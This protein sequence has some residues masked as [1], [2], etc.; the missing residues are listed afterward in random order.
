MLTF[1]INE[2]NKMEV[3][4]TPSNIT[5]GVGLVGVIFSVYLYFRNPQVKLEKKDAL[6]DQQLKFMQESTDRRFQEIQKNFEQL[7]L[8]SNNHIHTVDVKVDKMGQNMAEMT[9]QITRLG[10]I[11]EERMPKNHPHH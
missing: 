11:I 6:V 9:N 10:T 4:L 1:H 7:L 3:F 8:Q 5:F 2:D